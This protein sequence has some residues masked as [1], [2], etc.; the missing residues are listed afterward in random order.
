MFRRV[1]WKPFQLATGPR[2]TNAAQSPMTT[3]YLKEQC[4]VVYWHLPG[5]YRVW[6]RKC[7]LSSNVYF[8]PNSNEIAVFLFGK[9]WVTYAQGSPWFHKSKIITVPDEG[10]NLLLHSCNVSL[11]IN[12]VNKTAHK[13]WPCWQFYISGLTVNELSRR[14]TDSSKTGSGKADPHCLI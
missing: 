7:K 9:K 5:F 12:I 1:V 6:S 3:Y 13:L 4:A 14:P 2:E 11:S 10:A 8:P